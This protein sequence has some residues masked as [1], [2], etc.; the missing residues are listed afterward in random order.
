[1][2]LYNSFKNDKYKKSSIDIVNDNELNAS[3]SSQ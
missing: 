3:D 1:M 2:F